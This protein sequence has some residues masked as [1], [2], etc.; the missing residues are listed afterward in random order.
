MPNY[1]GAFGHKHQTILLAAVLAAVPVITRD[2]RNVLIPLG[3]LAAL[4]ISPDMDLNKNALGLLGRIGFVDEYAA[5]VPHRSRISHSPIFGTMIR[6]VL[7][8]GIP[9]LLSG[10]IF[11][12]WVPWMWIVRFLV[13]MCMAD[14]V[15]I[16]SDILLSEF[17]VRTRMRRKYGRKSR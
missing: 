14:I 7:V 11:G 10:G 16:L 17:K 9:M 6:F 15:H 4:K 3:T 5:L 2:W 12:F 13:G 8:F 1:R